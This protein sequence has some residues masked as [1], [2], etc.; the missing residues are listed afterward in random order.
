MSGRTFSFEVNRTST[1]PAAT[2]FRLVAD[3]G[4]WS[5]WAKPIVVSALDARLASAPT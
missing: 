5:T 3:G 2:L 1:A 4:N